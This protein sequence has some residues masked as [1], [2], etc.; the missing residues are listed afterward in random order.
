M[1]KSLSQSFAWSMII[2]CHPVD[3]E[4]GEGMFTSLMQER[5]WLMYL[6]ISAISHFRSSPLNV[7]RST[8]C[9]NWEMKRLKSARWKGRWWWQES[10][11]GKGSKKPNPKLCNHSLKDI[12]W[13][14][15][16]D[17]AFF[18]NWN[19]SDHLSIWI[20]FFQSRYGIK[21][22][23]HWSMMTIFSCPEQFNRW[24]CHSLSHWVSDFWVMGRPDLTEKDIP[25]YIHH[26]VLHCMMRT[27][28]KKSAYPPTFQPNT[29][30]KRS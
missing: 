22:G 3:G 19:I 26:F 6:I 28:T 12:D 8:R 17:K 24:P 16:Q 14:R 21:N 27:M 7:E 29:L 11:H 9:H 18:S 1:S 23:H 30:K 25:S 15:G 2:L 13:R 20:Y 5:K 4:R 10:I